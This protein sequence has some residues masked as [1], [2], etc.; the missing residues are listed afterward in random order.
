LLSSFW[1]WLSIL[2]III[3]SKCCIMRQCFSK[4]EFGNEISHGPHWITLWAHSIMCFSAVLDW[5]KSLHKPQA[6][7]QSW[8]RCLLKMSFTRNPGTLVWHRSHVLGHC[9]QNFERWLFKSEKLSICLQYGHSAPKTPIKPMIVVFTGR[10]SN[11]LFL[12]ASLFVGRFK[13]LEHLGHRSIEYCP[14]MFS[15]NKMLSK[16]LLQKLHSELESLQQVT[17]IS[18]YP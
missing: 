16:Q 7:L 10:F 6:I 11:H 4:F 1:T 17:G 9:R 15:W 14:L 5:I 12:P 13:I 2:D 3:F 18:K 8:F